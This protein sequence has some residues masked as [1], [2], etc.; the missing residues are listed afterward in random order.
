MAAKQNVSASDVTGKAP[1]VQK[2]IVQMSADLI[3][4]DF[5]CAT[6][7]DESCLKGPILDHIAREKHGWPVHLLTH[8]LTKD[9]LDSEG[10]DGHLHSQASQP[11]PHDDKIIPQPG[12]TPIRFESRQNTHLCFSSRFIQPHVNY[13]PRQKWELAGRAPVE[14]K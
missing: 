6:N 11:K 3:A 13:V 10:A 7:K 4:P 12:A 5:G 8:V 14:R 9:T 2:E 1:K